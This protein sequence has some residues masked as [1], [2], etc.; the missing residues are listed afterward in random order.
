MYDVLK[1]MGYNSALNECLA[2]G[3][4]CPMEDNCHLHSFFEQQEKQL[5]NSFKSKKLSKVK[6][7]DDQLKAA[8]RRSLQE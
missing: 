4:H 1:A 5:I 2:E 6:M 3:H 8:I 7:T